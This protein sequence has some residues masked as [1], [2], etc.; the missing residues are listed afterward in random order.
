MSSPA[1]LFEGFDLISVYTRRQAIADGVL[2]DAS[3]GDLAPV[4]RQ[5]FRVPVAMTAA[6]Y[7]ILERAVASPRHENDHRGVWHDVCSVLRSAISRRPAE[8]S[9]PELLFRVI[10]TGAG[11]SRYWTFKAVMGPDDEG[12][13]CLTIM[14]PEED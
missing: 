8:G 12:A 3:A 9:G 14:L 5:H 2:V 10:I 1:C 11:R 4:T 6:V 7:G 13:P